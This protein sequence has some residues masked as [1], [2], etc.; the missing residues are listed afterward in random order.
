MVVTFFFFFL[1]LKYVLFGTKHHCQ[2]LVIT[3]FSFSLMNALFFLPR[4]HRIFSPW[5]FAGNITT[6]CF[7]VGYSGSVFASTWRVLSIH[8]V[9]SCF[10]LNFRKLKV[11]VIVLFSCLGFLLWRLLPFSGSFCLG[12]FFFFF[13]L[14]SIFIFWLSNTWDLSSLMRDQTCAPC[15]GSTES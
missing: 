6:V 14:I 9:K 3:W 8:S 13:F 5:Y 2:C 10:I 1:Y 7:S 15:V 4:A 11:L 12:F